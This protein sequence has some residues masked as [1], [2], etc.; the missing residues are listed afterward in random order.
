MRIITLSADGLAALSEQVL[1]VGG[2]ARLGGVCV[3]EEPTPRVFVVN[4]LAHA[5]FVL[6]PATLAMAHLLGG[7]SARLSEC[8]WFG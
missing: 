7:D 6:E 3:S 8:V 1:F 2:R 5:V 4:T